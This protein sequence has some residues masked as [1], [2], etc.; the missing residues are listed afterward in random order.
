MRSWTHNDAN[1]EAVPA[2]TAW[3]SERRN[4]RTRSHSAPRRIRPNATPAS[5]TAAA[6]RRIMKPRGAIGGI[7]T[8]PSNA[9]SSR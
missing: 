2:S 3:I 4:R 1:A 8:A 5:H 7:S 9:Y 6:M